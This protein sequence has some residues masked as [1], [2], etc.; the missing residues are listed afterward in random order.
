MFDS[1]IKLI[2]YFAHKRVSKYQKVSHHLCDDLVQAACLSLLETNEVVFDGSKFTKRGLRIMS[3]SIDRELY[4]NTWIDGR[5]IKRQKCITMSHISVDE[6][7]YWDGNKSTERKHACGK[8][9]KKKN[10]GPQNIIYSNEC[11]PSHNIDVHDTLQ[12][13]LQY[14]YS[15]DKKIF[16]LY[17]LG[18][19]TTDIVR[20]TG[21]S[22]SRIRQKFNRSV[23][24][25]RQS[26]GE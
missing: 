11:S 12:H 4:N 21:L 15:E 7:T 25:I 23:K 8:T 20:I 17:S 6:Y 2:K 16:K 13:V 19:T 14:V 5:S 1:H 9:P 10:I 22:R 24:L 18:Y 3:T 26:T